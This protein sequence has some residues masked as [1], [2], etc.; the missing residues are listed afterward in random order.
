MIVFGCLA[1]LLNLFM[2][3]IGGTTP[4]EGAKRLVETQQKLYA[5]AHEYRRV[6]PEAF[7]GLDLGF[8]ERTTAALESLGFR[9]L[10]DVEDVSIADVWPRTQAI[11]RVMV[12][13]AGT[14]NVAVYHARFFGAVRLLQTVRL[15]PGK[16]LMIDVSSE[17]DSGTHVATGNTLKADTTAPFPR[18]SK[19][20]YPRDTPPDEL[21]RL[22]REH[23]RE[24]LAAEPGARPLRFET[25]EDVLAS[26][27]RSELIKAAHQKGIGYINEAELKAVLEKKELGATERQLLAEIEAQRR[28]NPPPPPPRA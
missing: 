21:L 8:Y 3:S 19:R 26:Q 28:T 22:H 16:L 23:L 12:G 11:L 20:R 15:L 2:R 4:E 24:A 14:T 18:H 10:G 5:G 13:E 1:I 27:N 25:L 7:N 6:G 17:L 9:Y